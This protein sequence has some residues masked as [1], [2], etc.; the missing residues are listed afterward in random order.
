[1]RLSILA[2]ALGTLACQQL[3][4][5]PGW[6]GLAGGGA[7]LLLMAAVAAAGRGRAFSGA[8]WIAAGALAGFVLAAAHAQVRLAD[9]LDPADEGQDVAIT[10]V[11]ASLPQATERG[12]RFEFEVEEAQRPVPKRILLSWYGGAREDDEEAAPGGGAG[13]RA[14]ERWAFTVRLKRPHGV[15]NPHGFDYEAWLME[16]GLRAT[17]YVRPAGSRRLDPFV[18]RPAFALQRLRESIRERFRAGLPEARYAGV[19]IGLAIG[20]QGSIEQD[21]WTLFNVTGVSHLMSVSGL[22]ITMIAGLVGAIAGGLWR[23]VPALALGLPAQK[24]A[25]LAGALAALGYCLLAGFGV[26]AQRTLY[27][28]SV[29][30]LALW[31]DRPV[32]ASRVLALALLAVLLLDPWAVLAAGF[33]LSFG[34][35]SVLFL[36]G[37]GRLGAPH[38]LLQALRTQWAVTLA[39]VPLLLALF[40]QF[41]LV[42]PLA[43]AVAIP[44]VSFAITPLALLAALLPFAPLLELAHWLVELLMGLLA[45]LADSPVA[46]WQQHAPPLPAVMAGLA[47]C[48]LLLMPR[49]FPLRWTGL[50]LMLPLFLLPPERPPAGQAR[51][52]VLDVGQGLAVHVQTAGHDLL[53]DTGPQYG[54][55]SDSGQRI[56]LP[57]LRALGVPALDTLV[58]SHLDSDH[59]G[60]AQSVLERLAVGEML[61]SLAPVAPLRAAPVPHRL[62]LAGTAWEWDG[63]AFELLHPTGADYGRRKAGTNALSCVLRVRAGGEALLLTGDIEAAQEEALARRE[64]AGLAARWLLVPHHGSKSSTSAAL[65]AATGAEAAL[66]SVGYRSRFRHPHPA[67]LERLET[68]GVDVWRTDRDGALLLQL[69]AAPAIRAWR[70]EAPRYWR[71]R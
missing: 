41:S 44:L 36:V 38:P 4:V 14:A 35:V 40:Q 67:T 33:W 28:L 59:S 64:P 6:Q 54:A 37:A 69:G 61:S 24:V 30:A 7:V 45:W 5:L 18:R 22:H 27:M 3:A 10:G 32:A 58:V 71:D 9:R 34:A 13:P 62:C 2:F 39:L 55:D 57:Y 16:R 15:A 46:A 12:L 1:M 20:D 11:V 31:S 48:G 52:T 29:V 17:G 47:G 19:L 50:A 42:S 63:V 65:L 8:L 51:V 23:R 56:V 68:A 49:G 70:R 21:D 60:G 25:L 26:P 66:I 53:Y 43:N